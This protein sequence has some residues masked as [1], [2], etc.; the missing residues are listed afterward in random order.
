MRCAPPRIMVSAGATPVMDRTEAGALAGFARAA[1]ADGFNPS[2]T[3][4][5]ECRREAVEWLVPALRE[6]GAH[7][8]GY[9][10][11]TYRGK[12]FG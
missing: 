9:A 2:R 10:P 1:G 8:R 12:L 7:R 11:G 5:P 3:V 4:A 6:R